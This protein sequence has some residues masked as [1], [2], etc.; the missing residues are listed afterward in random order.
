MAPSRWFPSE[1]ERRGSRD[2]H[3]R[4]AIECSPP[5]AQRVDARHECVSS[6]DERSAR[7][8]AE[9]SS[10]SEHADAEF[11]ALERDL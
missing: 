11:I 4:W 9:R 6:P 5:A 1:T 8:A 10:V 3:A 2:A 7:W